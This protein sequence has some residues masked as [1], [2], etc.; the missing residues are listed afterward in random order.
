M[1]KGTTLIE[2]LVVIGITAI[3]ASVT[4]LSLFGARRQNDLNGATQN[5]VA[6]LRE[7]RSRS[8]AQDS[9]TAWGVHFDNAAIPAFYALFK[10][11]YNSSNTVGYYSLPVN[12]RYATA[13]FSASGTL[14]VTFAQISG[15]PSTSTSVTLVLFGVV[16]PVSG[17]SVSRTSSGKIFF[18][19]FNRQSL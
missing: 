11:S 3:L 12:I 5:I 19:D 15:I 17:A 13:N 14:D 1:K 10:T 7:A 9:G 2:L 18:D 16:G 6:L 8:V 4:F